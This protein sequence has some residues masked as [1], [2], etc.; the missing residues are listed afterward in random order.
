MYMY[1]SENNVEVKVVLWL[2][3]VHPN[4]LLPQTRLDDFALSLQLSAD[5][6]VI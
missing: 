4:L 3:H 1:L 2:M 6:S 5:S